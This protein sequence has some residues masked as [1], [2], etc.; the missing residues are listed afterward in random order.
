MK[1]N[2]WSPG[3]ILNLQECMFKSDARWPLCGTDVESLVLPSICTAWSRE[4]T[5]IAFQ[6]LG[7]GFHQH[8][9]PSHWCRSH[10]LHPP[11]GTWSSRKLEGLHT[12]AVLSPSPRAL[13]GTKF[14]RYL[15]VSCKQLL[16]FVFEA[17]LVDKGNMEA[18]LHFTLTTQNGSKGEGCT[19]TAYWSIYKL[20][21]LPPPRECYWVWDS[22][23]QN[24]CK[25]IVW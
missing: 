22:S 13:L 10:L 12:T 20:S 25:F 18:L 14:C 7:V 15:N 5:T 23:S 9:A 24:T 2:A 6:G 4:V 19:Y 21:M 8:K 11:M 16:P 1:L 3:T 17:I